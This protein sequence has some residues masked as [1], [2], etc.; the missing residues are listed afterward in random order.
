MH[1]FTQKTLSMAEARAL[2]LGVLDLRQPSIDLLHGTIPGVEVALPSTFE[3]DASPVTTLLIWVPGA[4]LQH[5]LCFTSMPLW[6]INWETMNL[7]RSESFMVLGP[8]EGGIFIP[9]WGT[10]AFSLDS[11]SRTVRILLI[12]EADVVDMS[13]CF[14]GED[15]TD[16]ISGCQGQTLATGPNYS[17]TRLYTEDELDLVAH[18]GYEYALPGRKV[19][20]LERSVKQ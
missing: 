18:L 11:D 12:G 7:L 2:Y 5:L 8:E 19:Y 4:S 3:N 20:L 16:F 13:H 14:T 6:Q 15:L 10:D 1:I 9:M 17:C